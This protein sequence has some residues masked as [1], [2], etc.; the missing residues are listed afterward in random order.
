MKPSF[1]SA[2]AKVTNFYGGFVDVPTITAGAIV[3]NL[4]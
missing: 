3:N 2:V 1:A 4:Y